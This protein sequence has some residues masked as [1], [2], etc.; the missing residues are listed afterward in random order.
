MAKAVCKVKE[1]RKN[2]PFGKDGTVN[3]LRRIRLSGRRVCA[4]KTNGDFK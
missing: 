1:L 2:M 4:I 3:E